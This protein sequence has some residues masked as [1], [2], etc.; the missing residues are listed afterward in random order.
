[1]QIKIWGENHPKWV[2][3]LRIILGLILIW[4]GVSFLMNLDL[5]DLYLKQTGVDDILGLSISINFLAQL[6]VILNIFGGIC[7]ALNIY[8][9]M[10]SLFNLPVILGAVFFVN[11]RQD[12]FN[13]HSQF[14]IP[15]VVLVCIVSF[16]FLE[17]KQPVVEHSTENASV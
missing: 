14:W 1:M 12:G 2:D 15:L 3:Y 9:R 16:L 8:A 11:M 13:P 4:R 5:L 6:I 17:N 7:I 10:F